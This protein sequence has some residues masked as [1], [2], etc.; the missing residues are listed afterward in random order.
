MYIVGGISVTLTSPRI[1]KF[2]DTLGKLKS[3]RILILLSFIP[4]LVIT[5]LQSASI[6]L[7]LLICAFMFIFNSGRMIAAMTLITGAPTE[8]QRGK[9]L[10]IR[11]SLIELSEGAAAIIGGMI[12][13]QNATTQ[14]LE[15]YNIVG[16]VAV[17]IG[18]LCIYLAQRIEI[19]EE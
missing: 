6:M 9:F 4:I 1:G 17:G 13:T 5:H 15:N 11:S 3:F 10:V 2:I 7:A 19:N 8:E 16:Y 18:I 14:R 12:I